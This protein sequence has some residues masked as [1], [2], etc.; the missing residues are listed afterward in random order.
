[1][2]ECD[3]TKL[4]ALGTFVHR[5]D[6]AH[7]ADVVHETVRVFG[8]ERCLFGSNFPIEKL[9]TS[10]AELLSAHREA[11]ASFSSKDQQAILHDT[12]MRVY[13]IAS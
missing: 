13:R 12:A 5:N 8:P 9:W 4:S 7:V 10:Y 1:M 6:P 2:P 3:D 11:A